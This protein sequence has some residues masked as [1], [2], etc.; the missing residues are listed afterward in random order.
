M[1]EGETMAMFLHVMFS[2]APYMHFERD[3]CGEVWTRFE[4]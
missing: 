3:C 1:A 2:N 4:R